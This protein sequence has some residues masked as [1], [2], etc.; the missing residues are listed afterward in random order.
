M[1]AFCQLNEHGSRSIWQRVMTSL[2]ESLFSVVSLAIDSACAM[3]VLNADPVGQAPLEGAFEGESATEHRTFIEEW[4]KVLQTAPRMAALLTPPTVKTLEAMENVLRAATNEASRQSLVLPNDETYYAGALQATLSVYTVRPM[5]FDLAM[6][7]VIV[8]YLLFLL[9]LFQVMFPL[10]PPSRIAE[11]QT[12]VWFVAGSF[13]IGGDT[14]LRTQGFAGA[15]QT[16]IDL[17][18]GNQK[19][20]GK[21]RA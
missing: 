21:K 14:A 18:Q 20:Y 19:K 8:A 1:K 7:A 12:A 4:T 11:A 17:F 2:D 6:T 15:R 13:L 9:V 16:L 5:S 3:D 10:H